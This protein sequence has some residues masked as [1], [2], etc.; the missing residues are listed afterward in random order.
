M[1]VYALGRCYGS[2]TEAYDALFSST[3]PTI[4]QGC[5]HTLAKDN[6]QWSVMVQCEGSTSS[7]AVTDYSLVECNPADSVSDGLVLG[8]AI[9]AVWIAA[10]AI[11]VLSRAL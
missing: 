6:G 11:K 1:G 5:L 7:Y 3:V 4:S 9:A 10:Y 8:F 2:Q